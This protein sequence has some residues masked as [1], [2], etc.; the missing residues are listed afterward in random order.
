VAT[1]LSSLMT[2]GPRRSLGHGVGLRPPHYSYVLEYKPP[3]A[4]FEVISENFMGL[5]DQSGGKPV[6]VLERVRENYP[7]VLHGVSLSIGSVDPLNSIYLGK[8]KALIQ[9]IEPAWVADHFCWTGVDGENLHDLLPLPYNEETI[10]HVSSKIAQVQDFLGRQMLFENVSSY[11]TYES[12]E[13][14]EWAFI[15]E[16]AKRSGCGVLLDINNVFVSA[17]NHGFDPVEFLNGI[18][19][20]IVGQFH[21]AGHSQRVAHGASDQDGQG[22]K[23]TFLIDTHDHPVCDPVWALYEKAVKRFGKVPTLIEWDD[24]LPTFPEL[25]SESDKARAIEERVLGQ[26]DSKHIEAAKQGESRRTSA[27]ASMDHHRA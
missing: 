14:T 25:L 13:M 15:T 20:E 6:S 18:P 16:I 10:M 7:I 1:E 12:S 27:M 17:T 2:Q 4:W 5:G 21:L 19:V 9:Q 11:L 3:I 22:G 23:T 8:L 24:K 26:Q